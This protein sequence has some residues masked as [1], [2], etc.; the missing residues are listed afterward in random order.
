MTKGG[1]GVTRQRQGHGRVSGRQRTSRP[2]LLPLPQMTDGLVGQF[3]H[4]AQD[5]PDLFGRDGR[6][7]DARA[8][9]DG[10]TGGLR[11]PCGDLPGQLGFPMSGTPQGQRS[12]LT[13]RMFPRRQSQRRCADVRRA[14]MQQGQPVP[15]LRQQIEPQMQ[16]A[17]S[18]FTAQGV[19]EKRRCGGRPEV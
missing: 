3:V 19:G 16:A 2:A 17:L 8:A 1:Y 13:G 12:L 4:K 6:I 18:P 11:E 14:A 5:V 7:M 10:A 9:A 15:P